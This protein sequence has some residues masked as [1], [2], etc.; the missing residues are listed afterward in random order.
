MKCERQGFISLQ[1]S[2]VGKPTLSTCQLHILILVML[3]NI[4]VCCCYHVAHSLNIYS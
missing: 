2:P 1:C 4:V 3:T